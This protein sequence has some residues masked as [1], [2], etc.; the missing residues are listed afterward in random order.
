MTEMGKWILLVVLSVILLPF[1][2]FALL[3]SVK[4]K[5]RL[6]YREEK[7]RIEA[8][9]LCFRFP[10]YPKKEKNKKKRKK[11][12]KK[13]EKKKKSRQKA[14]KEGQTQTKPDIPAL[15]RFLWDLIRELPYEKAEIELR[16]LRLTVASGDAAKTALLYS[17]AIQLVTAML[18]LFEKGRKFVIRRSDSLLVVPDFLGDRPK[19]SMDMIFR[20]RTGSLLCRLLKTLWRQIQGKGGLSF[21]K[22]TSAEN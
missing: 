12:K 13:A 5:I 1:A 7:G 17:G 21:T 14:A 9:V 19:F 6:A 3:C 10:I 20:I 15:L 16:E 11:Q 8:G 18:A 2:L 4:L 22:S